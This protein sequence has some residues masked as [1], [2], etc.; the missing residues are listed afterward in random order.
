MDS[1]VKKRLL[2]FI[3]VENIEK[4]RFE[5]E[6]GLSNGF[7]DKVGSTIRSKSLDKIREKYP[8]FNI[9]WL[10]TGEGEMIITG[11][12]TIK[13]DNNISNTGIIGGN[14]DSGNNKR[15]FNLRIRDSI[16]RE[17][18]DISEL[19][20][21]EVLDSL[22]FTIEKQKEEIEQL[23]KDKAILQEFV[24]FLQNKK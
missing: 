5:K 19:S 8:H 9:D 17:I 13:G 20:V 16:G 11:D 24:T 22:V 6:S 10:L 7:V 18:K 2:Q 21:N 23:K 12:I 3:N 1:A 15:L 4:A 14:I